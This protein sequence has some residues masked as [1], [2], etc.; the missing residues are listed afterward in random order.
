M[1]G[2]KIANPDFL[3][4]F[5]KGKIKKH[6]EIPLLFTNKTIRMKRNSYI[7]HFV[8]IVVEITW[9][10][11]AKFQFCGSGSQRSRHDLHVFYP[12]FYEYKSYITLT[13]IQG[14]S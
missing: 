13:P 2:I 14:E 10:R 7:K 5:V 12:T 11:F 6:S 1:Q 9:K 4:H 8:F 3:Q